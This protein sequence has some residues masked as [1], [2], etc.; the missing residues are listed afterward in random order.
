MTQSTPYRWSGLVY[1][2][3]V[4]L[5]VALPLFG[6]P[7]VSSGSPANQKADRQ[8]VLSPCLNIADSKQ[9]LGTSEWHVHGMSMTR[10]NGTAMRFIVQRSEP[11]T[12][13]NTTIA[14]PKV[15]VTVVADARLPEK[16]RIV[17]DVMRAVETPEEKQETSE[18][19]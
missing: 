5:A 6:F 7:V 4:L 18:V 3:A 16:V 12:V 17:G 11:I 9:L 14:H 15:C 10:T 13:D 1:A 8:K 2:I 19:Q